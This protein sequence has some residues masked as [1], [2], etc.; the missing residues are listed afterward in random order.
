MNHVDIEVIFVFGNETV[1]VFEIEVFFFRVWKWGFYHL[2]LRCDQLVVEPKW[3]MF[4]FGTSGWW[5]QI[6]FYFHPCFWGK[7]NLILTYAYFSDGLKL[8]HQVDSITEHAF[9][10]SY[11]LCT[12]WDIHIDV[13]LPSRREMHCG[14]GCWGATFRWEDMEIWWRIISHSI[15]VWF[16]YLH[17]V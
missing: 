7:M 4:S 1:F 3:M 2:G 13:D 15:H 12:S 11:E 14:L 10:E 9:A 5:F 8:N 6:L 17:L 16:I